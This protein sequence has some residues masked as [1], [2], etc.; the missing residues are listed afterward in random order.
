MRQVRYRQ[1]H[2]RP[3]RGEAHTGPAAVPFWALEG[4]TR[5]QGERIWRRDTATSSTGSPRWQTP[6][7]FAQTLTPQPGLD[8]AQPA[9]PCASPRC[10]TRPNGQNS[11]PG[12]CPGWT[13]PGPTSPKIRLVQKERPGAQRLFFPCEK[14]AFSRAKD[15]KGFLQQVAVAVAPEQ[16]CQAICSD[17]HAG[18]ANPVEEV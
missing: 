10:P 11:N 14:N 2:D 16:G 8:P 4:D 6:A 17:S 15:N 12:A 3:G 1:R 18:R 5:P 7:A 9:K 13:R